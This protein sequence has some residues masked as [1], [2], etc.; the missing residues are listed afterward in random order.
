MMKNREPGILVVDDDPDM[1]V[2]LR[3]CLRPLTE[4]VIEAADGAEALALLDEAGPGAFDLVIADVMMPRM[5]GLALR[6]SLSADSASDRPPVLL[7]TGEPTGPDDEPILRK[8]FNGATLRERV[9][10]LLGRSVRS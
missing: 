4:R 6:R 1:R 8:P 10:G 2:Y 9:A 3:R 7:V 5:D